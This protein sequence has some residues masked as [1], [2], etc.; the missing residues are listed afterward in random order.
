MPPPRPF[1]LDAF[2]SR[3]IVLTDAAFLLTG[4]CVS[5]TVGPDARVSLAVADDMRRLQRDAHTSW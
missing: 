2:V 1:E 3:A 4:T 5:A